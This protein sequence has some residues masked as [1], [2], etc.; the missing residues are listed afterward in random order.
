MIGLAPAEEAMVPYLARFDHG[1]KPVCVDAGT[2][3]PCTSQNRE[4]E[5]E[6]SLRLISGDSRDD[7]NFAG[8]PLLLSSCSCSMESDFFERSPVGERSPFTQRFRDQFN[9]ATQTSEVLKH[10]AAT[11]SSISWDVLGFVCRNCAKPPAMPR[12]KTDGLTAVG[13]WRGRKRS[14][15]RTVGRGT[16]PKILLE[17]SSSGEKASHAMDSSSSTNASVE[18]D[19]PTDESAWSTLLS[20]AERLAEVLNT[21]NSPCST[22]L[23]G[24]WFVEMKSS[25]SSKWED[26]FILK[27]KFA[28]L[29]SGGTCEVQPWHDFYVLD[30]GLL[31]LEGDK[32]CRY[33]EQGQK[34]RFRCKP[35]E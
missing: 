25:H 14:D 18:A 15:S 30:G 19:E 10:D 5:D 1:S 32:L 23:D 4:A 3:V 27:G 26:E 8:G 12:S 21:S 29:A 28:L 9:A 33:D 31:S 22:S 35:L 6:P 34:F 20:N 17:G 16:P 11:L 24:H 2:Q 7:W 13:A